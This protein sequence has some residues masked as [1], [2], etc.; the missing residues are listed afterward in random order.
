MN[1]PEETKAVRDKCW[2]HVLLRVSELGRLEAD[3]WGQGGLAW[4]GGWRVRPGCVRGCVPRLCMV[5]L[6]DRE[7]RPEPY[8]LQELVGGQPALAAEICLYRH[9]QW[10]ARAVW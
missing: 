5:F 4:I 2:E 8:L 1:R 6:S 7:Q 10:A 3:A 9:A